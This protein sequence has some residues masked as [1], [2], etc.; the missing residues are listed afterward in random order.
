MG[1][2]V[3]V[4]PQIGVSVDGV[5]MYAMEVWPFSDQV[6]ILRAFDSVLPI[7]DIVSPCFRA[8]RNGNTAPQNLS[9]LPCPPIVTHRDGSLVTAANPAKA[10]EEVIALAVG[11]G[12]T[13]P[14][15]ETGKVVR[16]AAGAITEFAMDFNYRPNALGTRPPPL[17][18]PGVP[19]PVYVGSKEGEVGQYEV[20][21]LVPPV[22]AGTP[23]CARLE[24]ISGLP[25]DNVVYSNLTFS[26]GGQHSFDGAGICVAVTE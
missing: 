5:G 8:T 10:G 21:F 24:N 15:A 4:A 22:P 20:R 3:T 7:M 26:I 19:K 1:T 25:R 13:Y 9:S 12:H 2:I 18:T 11:L 6:H 17:G 16:T 14:L 23:P